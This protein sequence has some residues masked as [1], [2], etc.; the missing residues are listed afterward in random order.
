MAAKKSSSSP[1]RYKMIGGTATIV[2]AA[3]AG[4]WA[5]SHW[6]GDEDGLPEE[7]SVEAIKSQKTDPVKIVQAMTSDAL[8]EEQRQQLRQNLSEGWRAKMKE[9][10]DEYFSSADDVKTAILDKHL[11]EMAAMMSKLEEQREAMRAAWEKRQQERA[12]NGEQ[13]QQRLDWQNRPPQSQ[14]ERKTQSESR[15]PD[16]MVRM[17]SYFQALRARATERGIEMPSMMSRGF[18]LGGPGG[19]SGRGP[20]GGGPGGGRP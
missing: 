7:F 6:G 17:M 9:N 12:Q 4:V 14:E 15:T 3:A 5:W 10:L 1:F 16:D 11:D 8:T 19:W 13:P 2:L 18:G 20:G